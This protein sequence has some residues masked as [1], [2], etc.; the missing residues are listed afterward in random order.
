[1]KCEYKSAKVK[2]CL[3]KDA[4]RRQFSKGFRCN[5]CDEHYET[6]KKEMAYLKTIPDQELLKKIGPR[7]R[8]VWTEDNIIKVAKEFDVTVIE[9]TRRLVSLGLA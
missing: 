8:M 5:L 4:T 2:K 6:C 9:M 1:M 3:A 7:P